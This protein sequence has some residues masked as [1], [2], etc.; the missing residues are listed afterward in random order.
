MRKQNISFEN[1]AGEKLSGILDLPVSKPR[2]FALFA[3]CFTCSKNLRAATTISRALTNAGFA[4]LRFD[5]TGLG[6]SEGEFA[7]SNFSSNVEDLLAA[8]NYLSENHA[9][10]SILIG[11]SLGGT[12]VLQA[13]HSIPSAVA[14]ASI[15]SPANPSHVAHMFEGKREELEQAGSVEVNLGGRPF[16]IKRQFLQDLE[17]QE[18]P[19]SL[20]RLRKA[21]LI[22]HSPLDETVEIDNASE[23][24]QAAKHPKSFVSLDNADHLLTREADALYAGDVIQ[25]WAARFLPEKA[26]SET[27]VA[28]GVVLARTDAGGFF[29]ELQAGPHHL[30]ADEPTAVGG[31]NLGPTPY[32]LLSAALGACTTMTLQMYAA[33]KKLNLDSVSVEVSHGKVHAD[34]CVNCETPSAK[35]DEFQK[36]IHL[37]GNL[38]EDERKRLLE[39]ADRC[40]VHKTLHSEVIVRTELADS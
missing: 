20:G 9:A 13:A 7:D 6:Q 33:R 31:S 4:V 5:F 24:F 15:G 32:G 34:D 37:K 38:S 19:A 18:M 3:H 21:V 30:V 39:I 1:Q 35:V 17:Q 11:H 2:A 29:T 12:A 36:V 14:V 40:P 26:E 27:A 16:R 22:L 23:L 10:P 25:A 8:A 28:E